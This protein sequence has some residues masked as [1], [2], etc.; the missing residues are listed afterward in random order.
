MVTVDETGDKILLGRGVGASACIQCLV[1]LIPFLE[2]V[3]R[4]FLF[5]DGGFY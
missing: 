2:K 4:E 5:R 3:C 1:F